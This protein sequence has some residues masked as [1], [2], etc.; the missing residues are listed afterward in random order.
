MQRAEELRKGPDRE[1][2]SDLRQMLV[3]E[4]TVLMAKLWI[5]SLRLFY[6]HKKKQLPKIR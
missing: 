3:F 2:L 1:R 5:L 4:H 6:M